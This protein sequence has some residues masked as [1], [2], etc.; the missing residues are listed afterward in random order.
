MRAAEGRRAEV[1]KP[2]SSY[3]RQGVRSSTCSR[4]PRGRTPGVRVPAGGRRV[5][6]DAVA[7]RAGTSRT[8]GRKRP[9]DLSLTLAPWLAATKVLPNDA[10]SSGDDRNRAYGGRSEVF[11]GHR[12]RATYR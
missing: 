6:P 5:R 9:W 1:R 11:Y 8:P 12:T 3:Q 10:P 7:A 4:V 2:V